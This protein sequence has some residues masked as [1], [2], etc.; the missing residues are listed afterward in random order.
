[1]KSQSLP[2]QAISIPLAPSVKI[3]GV[4]Y[5][6][7]TYAIASS[8]VIGADW[9]V[10]GDIL[11][12]I[13]GA[14][15]VDS[16]YNV[17]AC[18]KIYIDS[19]LPYMDKYCHG[20][21]G[22]SQH[23]KDLLFKLMSQRKCQH[24]KIRRD[25][26]NAKSSDWDAVGRSLNTYLHVSDGLVVVHGTEVGKGSGPWQELAVRRACAEVIGKIRED[27]EWIEGVCDCRGKPPK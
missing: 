1:M 9:Q 10:L 15:L 11:E 18:R 14:I 23:P 6:T 22:E 2:P 27:K 21:H 17:E 25:G 8:I 24:F 4:T 20:P 13:I 19:I 7:I 5:P 12:S 26:L 16:G 3:G